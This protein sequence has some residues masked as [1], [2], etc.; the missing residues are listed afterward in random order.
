MLPKRV[1]KLVLDVEQP[2]TG[3]RRNVQHWKGNEREIC[4]AN[5]VANASIE[6]E[7]CQIEPKDA[8]PAL[9]GGKWVDPRRS[10]KDEEIEGNTESEQE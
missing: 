2:A 8:A 3:R 6:N 10:L 4:I 7:H 9:G 1:L 5:G